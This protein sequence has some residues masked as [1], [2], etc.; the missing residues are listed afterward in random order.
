MDVDVRVLA[1]HEVAALA[2]LEPAGRDFTAGMWAAQQRQESVLLVAWAGGAALGHGQ[3]TV[4]DEPELR[5]LHVHATARGRG[6]GTAIVRAAE[7]AARA[8]G[9]AALSVG[10]ADDNP[11]ARELY[12]RLGYVGTGI[13]STTTYAYV[14]DAGVRRT[15]TEVDELLRRDLRTPS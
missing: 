2:A 9:A 5:N 15:A 11:R 12:E 3:L 7:A 14:D 1:E 13:R 4:A 10:V 8:A 6:V